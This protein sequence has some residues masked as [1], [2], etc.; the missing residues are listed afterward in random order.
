MKKP[1]V[2]DIDATTAAEE[3]LLSLGQQALH[4]GHL[5]AQLDSSPEPLTMVA[6]VPRRGLVNQRFAPDSSLR[7]L[8]RR[9]QILSRSLYSGGIVKRSVDAGIALPRITAR[10]RPRSAEPILCSHLPPT[11]A[12][13]R[14]VQVVDLDLPLRRALPRADV[15]APSPPVASRRPGELVSSQLMC[16]TAPQSVRTGDDAVQ[17]FY[18]H[19][20]NRGRLGLFIHCNLV[21]RDPHVYHPYDLIAVDARSADAEHYV[22]SSTG[23]SHFQPGVC[24][25]TVT[26]LHAWVREV[27]QFKALRNLTFFGKFAMVRAWVRWTHSHR[28]EK[29]A[30]RAAFLDEHHPMLNEWFGESC[31]HVASLVRHCLDPSRGN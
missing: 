14:P 7:A 28:R 6:H 21:N 27:R 9:S 29:F 3:A 30:R 18:D 31:R 20:Q 13:Y 24:G 5:A 4:D 2:G 15:R 26:P 1:P 23:V 17:F 12:S 11:A 22:V 25:N 10:P 16:V 19:E 8:R